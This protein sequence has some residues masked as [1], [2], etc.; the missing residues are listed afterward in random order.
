MQIHCRST[1]TTICGHVRFDLC[2]VWILPNEDESCL[3]PSNKYENGTK[4]I[5]NESTKQM[6]FPK[7][8][9][10]HLSLRHPQLKPN[11]I[12]VIICANFGKFGTA[13]VNSTIIRNHL[14]IPTMK[15]RKL[16]PSC[17]WSTCGDTQETRAVRQLKWP[18]L[19][20]TVYVAAKKIRYMQRR[21]YNY[22]SLE[23]G[24]GLLSTH[25]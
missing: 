24:P 17:G 20:N 9:I 12:I 15:T 23:G 5:R 8:F 7:Y 18:T 25:A 21:R 14:T 4:I 1:G 16:L 10:A 2:G 13:V 19:F 6:L 3:I 11:L 22:L